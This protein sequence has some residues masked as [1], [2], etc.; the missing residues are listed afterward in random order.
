MAPESPTAADRQTATATEPM[1]GDAETRLAA[2]ASQID[3]IRL[4]AEDVAAP[5]FVELGKKRRK[6][7]KKLKK[8]GGPLYKEVADVIDQVRAELGDDIT[9]KMLLPVVIIY[10]RKRR[11][12]RTNIGTPFTRS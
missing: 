4:A 7:I 10:R 3:Q 11:R 6:Q 8:G 12:S 9:G 5:V 1:A 2:T